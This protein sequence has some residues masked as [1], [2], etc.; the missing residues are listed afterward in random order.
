MEVN[1]P[2]YNLEFIGESMEQKDRG[3]HCCTD[4]ELAAEIGKNLL[5]RNKELEVMLK[6]SHQYL[7]EQTVKNEFLS[8]QLET[9]RELHDSQVRT[10]EQMESTALDLQKNNKELQSETAVLRKRYQSL[11]QTVDCLESK[12]DEYKTQLEELQIERMR[13][14]REMAGSLSLK[15]TPKENGYELES[16]DE[17]DDTEKDEKVLGFKK[18]IEI[19]NDRIMKLKRQ[20]SVERRR[21]EEL[22]IELSDLIHENQQLDKELLDFAE[23][24]KVWQQLENEVSCLSLSIDNSSEHVRQISESTED[25]SFVL[26]ENELDRQSSAMSD[27]SEVEVLSP[28]HEVKSP[29]KQ[30]ST[31]FLSELGSQYHELVQKYDS[32]VKRCKSEGIVQDIAP[33]PTVQRAIQTSPLDEVPVQFGDDTSQQSSASGKAREYRQL[34]AQIYSKIQESKKF[35]PADKTE[36]KN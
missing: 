20:H 16:D 19:L 24:A 10:C 15:L 31:S 21:R 35:N 36:K 9:L 29:L 18:D 27:Q 3:S 2:L 1:S 32:L 11:V 25:E 26:V 14:Q 6:S 30:N 22:E 8:K 12:C 23:Q 17:S 34:F 13:L 5:E 4:L 33:I 7:E 28:S